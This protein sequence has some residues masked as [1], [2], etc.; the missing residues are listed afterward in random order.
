VWA[1]L[2]VCLAGLE[3]DLTAQFGAAS[4]LLRPPA[5]SLTAKVCGWTAAE[6]LIRLVMFRFSLLFELAEAARMA[7]SRLDGLGTL[8]RA[9]LRAQIVYLLDRHT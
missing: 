6:F 4:A 3:H 1:L 2:N 7:R 9:T 8:L 5:A